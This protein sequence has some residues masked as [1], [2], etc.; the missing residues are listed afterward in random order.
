MKLEPRHDRNPT[1]ISATARLSGFGSARGL[2]EDLA[3]GRGHDR[4]AG[5]SPALH[6]GCLGRQLLVRTKRIGETAGSSGTETTLI[7]P[8]S[9]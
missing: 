5:W 9:S 2:L 6:R 1:Q 3:D 4:K 7:A 8:A